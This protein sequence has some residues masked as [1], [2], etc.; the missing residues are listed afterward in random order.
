MSERID[1]FCED[2]RRKLTQVDN[3][4]ASFRAKVREGV[5]HAQQDVQSHLDL[6]EKRI[7]QNR[8]KLTAAEANVKAWI[9]ERNAATR[10]KIAEWKAKQEIASLENQAHRAEDYA[11]ATAVIAAAAVDDAEHALLE[12]WIARADVKATKTK[13]PTHAR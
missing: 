3:D 5:Q 10:E 13:Q 1:Q 7:E 8:S 6:V 12:A 9:N 4:L 2:L 11:A